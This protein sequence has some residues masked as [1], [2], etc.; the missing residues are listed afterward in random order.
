MFPLGSTEF[1]VNIKPLL[2]EVARLVAGADNQVV[3][4]GHTDGRPYRGR[5]G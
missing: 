2:R 1:T 4:S 5:Q 3:I